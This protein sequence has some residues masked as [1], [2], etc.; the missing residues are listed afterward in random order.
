VEVTLGTLGKALGAAGGFVAGSLALTD[1]LVN[2]ARSFVFST[3]PAP[4]VA[5]AARAA[6]ELV[7][8]A[9]GEA[10]A[11]RLWERVTQMRTGLLGLG[12][13]LAPATSAIL[14]LMVG[15]EEVA[16]R[17]AESLR[18]RGFLVPGIRHPTVP[19]GQARLRVTLSADHAPQD[20]ED[21]VAALERAMVEVGFRPDAT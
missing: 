20:V 15:P 19:R 18:T 4:A 5:A 8:S 7:E 10:R 2:R 21:F 16:M 9:E 17:L 6:L 14:P 1:Y 11:R 12:W 3:A 13:R